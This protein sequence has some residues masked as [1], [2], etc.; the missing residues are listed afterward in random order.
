MPWVHFFIQQTPAKSSLCITKHANIQSLCPQG[1]D[2]TEGQ[3]QAGHYII[4]VLGTDMYGDSIRDGS[5]RRANTGA[6]S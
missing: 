1:I 2:T 5:L 6:K 4:Q 3:I